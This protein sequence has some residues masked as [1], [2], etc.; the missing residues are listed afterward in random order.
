MVG[1]S[2]VVVTC[3]PSGVSSAVDIP[4][5]LTCKRC[6]AK[7]ING[8]KC[9]LCQNVFHNS[10]AK[11]IGNMKFIDENHVQCC[12]SANEDVLV[13]NLEGDKEEPLINVKC[14]GSYNESSKINETEVE[15]LKAL[16]ELS[17]S[18]NKID[19]RIVNYIIQQKD[20]LITE[21][22]RVIVELR[23][24]V[25]ILMNQLSFS[26]NISKFEKS[27][28]VIN[29]SKL[30]HVNL[31]EV[32]QISDNT[33]IAGLF[34]SEENCNSVQTRSIIEADCNV[35]NSDIKIKTNNIVSTENIQNKS[36]EEWTSV[37]KKNSHKYHKR[38]IVNGNNSQVMGLKTVPKKTFL[39]ISRLDP[40]TTVDMMNKFVKLSFPE[41]HCELLN[42]KFPNL[43]SSFK[44]T[45][46][47]NNLD[48]A[49]DATEWPQ[50]ALVTRF[51]QKK[52][53]LVDGT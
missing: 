40:T 41:A 42:S 47:L 29:K 20:C 22:D 3:G 50:G 27:S 15:F 46:N 26:S 28:K 32:K 48:R 2:S 30:G 17:D 43:Y 33:E 21:K 14:C 10:C 38:L 34:I 35:Q 12:E 24:K 19:V 6:K 11:L 45:I 4:Y 7:L 8:L 1:N 25:D 51:F 16:T 37:V 39:F 23:E 36:D 13:K 52:I 53:P 18:E 9:T 5:I 31:G 44:V 49:L